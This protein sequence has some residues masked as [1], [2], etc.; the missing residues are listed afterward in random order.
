MDNMHCKK[1]FAASNSA[2]GFVNYF[3]EIF[4]RER[5]SKIYIIKGGPGTGKSRF[6]RDVAN[7]A[8]SRG[9]N[10]KYYYCSSDPDS[11]DGIIIEEMRLGVLDGTAPHVYE[12][13]LV[14][15]REQIINLGDFWDEKRLSE[16]LKDI[17]E[18]ASK[19][20]KSYQRAYM[21]LA[22]YG[23][24]IKAEN[25]LVAPCVNKKKLVGAVNRYLHKLPESGTPTEEIA[26]CRAVGMGGKRKFET[27][28]KNAKQLFSVNDSYHAAHYFLGEI[29]AAARRKNMSFTVSYDP[30]MPSRPDAVCLCDAGI[31]FVIGE[32]CERKINIKRFIDETELKQNKDLLKRLESTAKGLES[33]VFDAFEEIKKY[34]F[35]L[36]EIYMSAMDFDKKERYTD[37]FIKKIFK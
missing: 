15:A 33:L 23:K 34:H 29:V 14:G 8:E 19:K 11:L 20:S 27:Y 25:S 32:H 24:L 6:M 7:E 2:E 13:S 16:S 26:L 3:P 18:L 31:T 9:L 10:V 1:Y 21:L 4:N 5:C 12:P 36:E 22:A 28:E 37:N 30:I 35:A 17:E